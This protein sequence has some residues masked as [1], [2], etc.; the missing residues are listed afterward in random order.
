MEKETFQRTV[1]HVNRKDF[2]QEPSYEIGAWT[3]KICALINDLT[4][5]DK[6]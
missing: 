3:R 2:C 6:L 5:P 4:E 1:A